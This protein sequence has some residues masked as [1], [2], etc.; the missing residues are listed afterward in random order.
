MPDE[1]LRE[2]VAR[3][4][5][6]LAI[7]RRLRDEAEALLGCLRGLAVAPSLAA[8]DQLLLHALQPVLGHRSAALLILGDDGDL[9]GVA[10]SDPE[11][12]PLQLR[13]GPLLR[14]VLAGQPAAVFDLARVPELAP[15]IGHQGA[16]S[17]LCV[18]IAAPGRLTLLIGL[19]PDPA[20]FS[21]RQ[22]GLARSF[23]EAAAPVLASLGARED[24]QRRRLA[25]A[26]AD[27]LERSNTAL[28]EQLATIVRQQAQIQRLVGP[29]LRVWR[30]VLV[31]PIIGALDDAQI[32]GLGERLLHAI[33]DDRARVAI[34]DLTGLETADAATADHLR[35]LVRAA[36]LLGVRGW[37]TGLRPALAAVLASH[38]AADLRCFATLADGLAAALRAPT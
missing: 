36:A 5:Q 15:L 3:L 31:M 7:E 21:P 34:L 38:D 29:V 24:A 27:E 37:L 23:A 17:A 30:G 33:A 1:A 12:P 13:P 11:H 14:R 19:H 28:H 8:A 6:N 18:A 10:A 35:R 16:R 25:E 20:A 4:E 22:S 32:A 9:H 26:R 2:A